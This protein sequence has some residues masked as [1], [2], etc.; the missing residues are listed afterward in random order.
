[1]VSRISGDRFELRVMKL[2]TGEGMRRLTLSRA[3]V[4]S[5]RNRVFLLLI[6]VALFFPM[7]VMQAG[8]NDDLEVI[9]AIIRLDPTPIRIVNK[10]AVN[11]YQGA[12]DA[13][14]E[15]KRLLLAAAGLTQFASI[16]YYNNFYSFTSVPL[17][18]D[19]KV[20]VTTLTSNLRLYRRSNSAYTEAEHSNLGKWW[21]GQYRGIEAT[22]NEQ[23]V[24]SAWGSDLNR[25]YVIDAPAGTML[26]GGIAS[27]M[28]KDDEYRAGGAYQYFLYGAPT[29]WLVYALYA[30]DYLKSYSGA[31]TSAQRA[32]R[33]IASDLGLHLNQARYSGVRLTDGGSSGDAARL[34]QVEREGEFWLRGFAGNSDY[35]ERDN[36]GVNSRTSGMSLGWQRLTSG[37]RLADNSRSYFG[38]MAATS[39]NLQK[40]ASNVENKTQVSIGGIYGMYVN[41]PDSARSWYG[42][43]SLLHGGLSFNNTVPGELGYG[44]KQEYNG[45]ITVLTLENG[46]SLRQKY[47]W[48]LEPQLQLSYTKVGQNDFTDKL[49]AP[50]SLKQGEAL[51]GRLGLEARRTIGRQSQRQ[52]SYWA[53]LSYIHQFSGRNEVDIAGDRAVSE[54]NRS[55]G[56]LSLGA[57]LQFDR[58]WSLQGEVAQLFGGETGFQGNLALK[59]SW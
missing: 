15:Q 16:G 30:P 22:R 57:D 33:S 58:K 12:T 26:I 43:W 21:G 35:S 32:G 19:T 25:I 31:V 20:V 9:D 49:G 45:N 28:E 14:L 56:Q 46:V 44:L 3:G 17:Y 29:S 42:H 24:L 53:K 27:P 2:D 52:S 50:V 7:S 47:G 4:L 13:W 37:G 18:T 36:S 34:R 40:Y 8:I 1:V 38:L 54:A 10:D 11:I 55:S 39:N 59:C 23:A 6:L 41:R 48:V 51:W 5:G